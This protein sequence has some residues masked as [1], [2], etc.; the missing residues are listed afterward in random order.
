MRVKDYML[1]NNKINQNIYI[2]YIEYVKN[3]IVFEMIGIVSFEEE[4]EKRK[5]MLFLKITNKSS[6]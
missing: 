3:T 5:Y 4:N 1:I 2:N 6:S